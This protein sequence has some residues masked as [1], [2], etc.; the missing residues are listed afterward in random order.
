MSQTKVTG[1]VVLG[2]ATASSLPVTGSPVTMIVL[3]GLALVVGG[4][5]MLRAGR[6]Q[7]TTV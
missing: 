4:L 7:R 2:G 6:Y 5:L 3:T 1:T